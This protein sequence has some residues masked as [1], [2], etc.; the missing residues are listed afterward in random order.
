MFPVKIFDADGKLKK[1]D[2]VKEQLK[3]MWER[4]PRTSMGGVISHRS[5]TRTKK[6]ARC[7]KEFETWDPRVKMC[8]KKCQQLQLRIQRKTA[9][10][11]LKKKA[12]RKIELKKKKNCL[13]CG[14]PYRSWR[15][16]KLF[17]NPKCNQTFH[18]KKRKS[19]K[20]GVKK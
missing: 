3:A 9:P 4:F 16:S 5:P 20:V 8:S 11:V 10:S 18:D 15:K 2:S 7:E 14:E 19:R 1:T 17:C 13:Y 12:E 6:C